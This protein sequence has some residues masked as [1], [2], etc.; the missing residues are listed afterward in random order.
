M[1]RR[2]NL[3]V[4]GRQAVKWFWMKAVSASSIPQ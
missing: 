1:L 2:D 4:D 3:I